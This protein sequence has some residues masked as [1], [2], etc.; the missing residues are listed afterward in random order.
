MTC[1]H[2]LHNNTDRIQSIETTINYDP[3]RYIIDPC[4]I[5]D[6]D[7]HQTKNELNDH[8]ETKVAHYFYGFGIWGWR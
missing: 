2:I 4:H 3:F 5:T 7:A 1:I 8:N 6:E